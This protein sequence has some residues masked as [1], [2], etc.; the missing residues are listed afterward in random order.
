MSSR[1]IT[2]IVS[3][4]DNSINWVIPYKNSY[5]EARYVRRTPQ[6]ISAYVSSHNGCTMG[7]K[8]C[9]LTATKQT[10]FNHVNADEYITQLNPIL[11]H[12]KSIDGDNSQSVRV[13]IN[14]MARGEA[15]ANKTVVNNYAQVYTGFE[16]LVKD[17]GYKTMKINI[18][19]IMPKTIQYRSLNDIFGKYPTNIYYSIYGINKEFRNKWIPNA[20][21]WQLA[22]SKLKEYQEKTSNPITFHFASIAGQNDKIDEV[23]QMAEEIRK[24][25]FSTTKFNLVRLNLHPNM[26]QYSESDPARLTEIYE[27]MKSACCDSSI[28]TNR[29]RIVPRV[30]QDVFA[31][32]GMFFDD[33]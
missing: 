30:G 29:S 23:K 22:L 5:L 28:K 9:W 10:T 20:M 24:L 11:E 17:Y 31:S 27:I 21:D 7:C 25:K 19:T 12:A 32:C 14:F 1:A 3:K 33:Q 15:L 2:K 6:Y 26:A 4:L 13:N 18:S 16:Q 8:F